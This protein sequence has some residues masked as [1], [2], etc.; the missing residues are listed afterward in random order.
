MVEHSREACN[1]L[2]IKDDRR[3]QHRVTNCRCTAT[4]I[5][6]THALPLQMPPGRAEGNKPSI[7]LSSA[8]ITTRIRPASAAKRATGQRRNDGD[9]ERLMSHRDD[10]FCRENRSRTSAYAPS[11]FGGAPGSSRLSASRSFIHAKC[12]ALNL[13]PARCSK[14]LAILSFI[15]TEIPAP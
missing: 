11:C 14:S 9:T 10:F 2:Q 12:A 13:S 15:H 5:A 4:S 7:A 8:G 3:R 1:I 6:G